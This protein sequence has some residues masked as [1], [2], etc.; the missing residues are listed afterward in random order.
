MGVSR[1]ATVSPSATDTGSGPVTER[2][3]RQAA[4]AGRETEWRQP[5][6]AE[7]TLYRPCADWV[8][9]ARETVVA[10][11]RQAAEAQ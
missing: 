1:L 5:S 9:Q 6:F 7:Q 4:E 10:K 2:E 3:A 8:F 11:G